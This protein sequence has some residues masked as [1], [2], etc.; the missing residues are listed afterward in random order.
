MEILVGFVSVV[1]LSGTVGRKLILDLLHQST[2]G[3]DILNFDELTVLTV[4]IC[5]TGIHTEIIAACLNSYH[6]TLTQDEK[7]CN[8]LIYS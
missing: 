1:M 8:K 7:W 6:A 4:I 2:S 3:T 5:F